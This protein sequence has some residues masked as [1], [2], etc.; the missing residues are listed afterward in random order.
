MPFVP[1]YGG[2][3]VDLI[4]HVGKPIIKKE[5]ESVLEL[6]LRVQSSMKT[7]IEENRGKDS[8]MEALYDRFLSNIDIVLKLMKLEV[9]LDY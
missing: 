8:V 1:F 2:F 7:I 3:P 5:G 6:Q 9:S 4:T